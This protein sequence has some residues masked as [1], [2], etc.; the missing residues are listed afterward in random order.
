[1][2]RT[3]LGETALVGW[4]GKVAE[5]LAGPVA[6]RTRLSTDDARTLIGAAFFAL[7]CYYV[8]GTIARAAKQ[9]RS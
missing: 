7:A 1:M 2:D 5:R 4:R 9:A 3:D 6:D 8:V